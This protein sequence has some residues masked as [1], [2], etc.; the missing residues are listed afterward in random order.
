MK[1]RAIII[2]AALVVLGIGAAGAKFF[3]DKKASEEQEARIQ[4]IAQG[5]EDIVAEI[6]SVLKS[7][8]PVTWVYDSDENLVMTLKLTSAMQSVQSLPDIIT[9]TIVSK[10]NGDI[11]GL[12]CSEYLAST[13]RSATGE[14]LQGYVR[15]VSGSFQ[16]SDLLRYLGITS[17]YGPDCTGLVD[18]CYHYFGEPVSKLNDMQLQ[19]IAYTYRNAEVSVDDYLQ[20]CNLTA[21]RLKFIDTNS[22]YASLQSLIVDELNSIP[23]VDLTSQSYSVKL[24]LSSTQQ[25]LYQS[26]VDSG[27]RKLID[28]NVDGS[29]A[30]DMSVAVVD[31]VSGF[32]RA[33]IPGRTVK[34]SKVSAYTLS[35]GSFIGNLKALKQELRLPCTYRFSLRER[36][37]QNGDKE[38][39]T[40]QELFINQ[41]LYS[42]STE[43]NVTP[44]SFLNTIY[45]GNDSFSG[46]SLVY[47]VVK[48]DGSTVYLNPGA[49]SL[50]FTNDAIPEFFSQDTETNSTYG[51][52]YDLSSGLI[53]WKSTSSYDIVAVAGTTAI[54]GVI[55]STQRSELLNVVEDLENV[56]ATNSPKPVNYLWQVQN[57]EASKANAYDANY[58]LVSAYVEP[59]FTEL[60]E[61]VIDSTAA[62]KVFE[63]KFSVIDKFLTQHENSLGEMYTKQMR[64]RLSNV[65]IKN[66]ELLVQYSV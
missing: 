63:D 4:S 3:L 19:F 58:V 52:V 40:L 38:L 23:N 17:P 34:V 10:C 14:L 27:T 32:L 16:R 33:Y 28:L 13:G 51:M 60:E 20:S 41:W 42:D 46:I 1:K 25:M 31:K 8:A 36:T 54:G 64:E 47:Q 21:D 24:T 43:G 12:V 35:A 65:R 15:R 6:N 44:L 66:R 53:T 39:R 7:S 45:E 5:A 37:K 59:L 30:Q 48:S 11:P 56:L 57:I 2:I 50:R 26:I 49:G 18:A 22:N 62:R 55:N 9:S 61:L 29:Y